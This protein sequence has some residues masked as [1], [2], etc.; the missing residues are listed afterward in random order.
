MSKTRLAALLAPVLLFGA[1][2]ARAAETFDA[3]N[4]RGLCDAVGCSTWG[5]GETLSKPGYVLLTETAGGRRLVFGAHVRA[6]RPSE[7]QLRIEIADKAGAILWSST[8]PGRADRPSTRAVIYDD[9]EIGRV[10]DALKAGT[11]LKLGLTSDP[12]PAATILL[13]NAA[14]ALDWSRAKPGVTASP[15]VVRRPPG[16]SPGGGPPTPPEVAK[17][18]EALSEFATVRLAP[19]KILWVS[20]CSGAAINEDA[21]LHLTDASGRLLPLPAFGEGPGGVDPELAN[22]TY[23][24][25]TRVLSARFRDNRYGGCGQRRDWVWDGARFAL[26]REA[27]ADCIGMDEADWPTTFRAVVEER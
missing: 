13:K 5:A 15:P 10:L 19:D 26:I 7:G 18:C 4:W 27:S 23:D 2:S 3:G 21:K 6:Q 16:L 22:V 14:P 17:A 20:N 1:G 25:Q 11:S 8:L 24:Y 12:W 9:A